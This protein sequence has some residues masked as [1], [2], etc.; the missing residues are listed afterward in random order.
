MN[1]RWPLVV[2]LAACGGT[3]G[4]HG[5]GALPNHAQTLESELAML[6][7]A[8]DPATSVRR[9][10]I[11][12]ALGRQPEALAQLEVAAGGARD[13]LDWGGLSA[14]WREVGDVHLEMGRPQ[15]ALDAFGKRLKTAV[16]LGAQT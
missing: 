9:S 15:Q 3:S 6:G 8:T 14:L 11:L 10:R 4:G 12:R 7:S 5:P 1:L 13:A 16:S 2:L